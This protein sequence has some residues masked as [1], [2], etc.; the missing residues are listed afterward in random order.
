MRHSDGAEDHGGESPAQPQASPGARSHGTYPPTRCEVHSVQTFTMP[1]RERSEPNGAVAD[2]RFGL[3]E[4][5][6][7]PARRQC[8]ALCA[9]LT[10][11]L[12]T[13]AASPPLRR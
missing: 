5:R 4:T 9:C 7:T 2:A 12:V 11:P 8:A 13:S 1:A 3:V 6:R 10:V